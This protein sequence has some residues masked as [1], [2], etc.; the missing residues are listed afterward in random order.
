MSTRSAGPDEAAESLLAGTRQWIGRH[1]AYLDSPSGRAGLPVTPRVK[2]LLQLALLCHYERRTA[3]ADA[4]PGEAA[5]VVERAWQ[6]PD[7]T[8]L[9]GSTPKYAR[10]FQLIHAALAPAGTATAARRGMLARLAADGHLEPGRKQPYF[11][12]ETRFFADLAGAG[13]RLA[14]YREL[15]AS[16]VLARAAA[17]P[18]AGLD[19]CNITHTVFYLSDFGFRDPG[20]TGREREEALGV[21]ERLTD[22]CVRRGEWDLT[23]K[24]VLAQYC[25]GDDPLRT[26]SGAAG[27]RMLARAQSPGG[28]IPGKSVT[29]RAAATATPEKFFRNAYQ[30]TVVTA[31]TMLIVT[32]GRSG[33]LAAAGALTEQGAR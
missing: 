14:P 7:F 10:Q 16:S 31:L 5:T 32:R 2:A 13:H 33:K 15:F 24:L 1:A 3:P 25:L 21:V 8:H 18:V 30:A 29:E 6:Q 12:L 27:V 23:G 4:A 26:P 28:A 20:L 17:L 22:R 11:H 9:L 19:V